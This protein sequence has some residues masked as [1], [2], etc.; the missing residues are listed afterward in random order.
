MESGEIIMPVQ[1]GNAIN[2]GRLYAGMVP[3]ARQSIGVSKINQE[4]TI[5]PFGYGVVSGTTD[6]GMKLPTNTSTAAKFTGVVKYELNRAYHDGETMGA[7]PKYDATVVTHGPIAVA[8]TV[9]VN[10]DDP[11]YL[12][13][14]DGTTPN[15]NLGRFSNVVGATTETAVLIP[16]AKWTESLDA[17][18]VGIVTLGIGG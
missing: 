1:G 16:G 14:G 9:A 13:V 7:R 4:S 6:D 8:P 15:A 11:V 18:E 12:I 2:H 5:I 10:R 3:D 17:G